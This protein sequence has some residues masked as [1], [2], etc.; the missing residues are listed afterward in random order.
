MSYKQSFSFS[1]KAKLNIYKIISA[2]NE[3]LSS[4]VI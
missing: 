4:C 1:L 3:V 2:T